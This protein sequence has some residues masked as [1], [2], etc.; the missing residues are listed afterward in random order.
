MRTSLSGIRTL[1]A[2]MKPE[3]RHRRRKP[4]I[5]IILSFTSAFT[6]IDFLQHDAAGM[7][8]EAAALMGKPGFED[9]ML[10]AESDTAAYG[11]QFAKARE[12][13]RRASDSA[14]RADE[15]ET[16]AGYEAEAA[17]RE[18]LVGNMSHAKQQA[19]AAL[20]LSTGRDVEAVS[21]IALAL[22]GDAPQATRLAEDLAKRFPEDTIVQ[23]EYLPMIHAGASLGSGSADQ[24]TRSARPGC[25]L[26]TR[27]DLIGHS[28]SRLPAWRSLCGNAPRQRS[29]SRVPENSRPPGRGAERANR[30]TGALGSGPRLRP[31]GRHRQ[32]EECLPGLPRPLERRRPRHPHPEGSQGGVREAAIAPVAGN[33]LPTS[34]TVNR[35]LA[36]SENSMS[37]CR[38]F[39]ADD[40]QLLPN[41][42]K[43]RIVDHSP[44][45]I[46]IR[47]NA[48]H[49]L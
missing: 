3:P 1:T 4:T 36:Q 27:V 48:L 16:A 38:R 35:L 26:R 40:V 9:A 41:P 8:R 34:L 29:R 6:A 17:V 23:L 18:A 11:G 37:S 20:A 39:W 42:A 15:K 31:L 14:Q 45:I 5:W 33:I 13:T 28:L 46:A 19:Q 12:L 44:R 30:R 49:R 7:E 32:S 10:G 47:C 43:G 24:G 25:A 21:A 2:S 22:A